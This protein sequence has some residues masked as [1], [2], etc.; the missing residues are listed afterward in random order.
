MLRLENGLVHGNPINLDEYFLL[1]PYTVLPETRLQSAAANLSWSTDWEG[2]QTEKE[3]LGRGKFQI[4]L[5]FQ[6]TI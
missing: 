6:G 2:S 4:D 3:I 1:P 5:Q